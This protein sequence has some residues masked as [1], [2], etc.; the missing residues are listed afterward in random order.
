MAVPADD[1]A[2]IPRTAAF[3]S[4]LG[5]LRDGYTFGSRRFQR[6]GRDVFATRIMLKPVICMRGPEAARIFYDGDRFTRQGA[7][8]ASVRH[9]LQDD[10]SVQGLDGAAHRHRK[11]LFMAL[12]TDAAAIDRLVSLF[13]DEWRSALPRWH[14]AGQIVLADELPALLT[15][16]GAAWAGVP[17]GAD[18]RDDRAAELEAMV[19]NAGRVGPSNW[20]ARWRRRRTERWAE[21]ALARL[22]DRGAAPTSPAARLAD[23][24]DLDGR[25]LPPAIAAVE[26]INLLRPIV[27]VERY[28][29]FAALALHEH[30]PWRA[31][32]AAG[33]EA[34]LLP[35]VQEVR[36]F[37]PFFPAVAGRVRQAFDWQGTRFPVGQWVLLDIHG[38]N[39]HPAVWAAPDSFRPERFRDWDEDPYRMVPQGAG[40]A[41]ETH[42]CPGERATI[43]LVM[44][45]MRLLTRE[46]DWRLPPQD[47]SVRLNR[48]PAR[49]ASGLAMTGITGLPPV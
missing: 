38:T 13:A 15:R 31:R 32:F 43:A 48:M 20:W 37:Y 41:A 36:R 21:R 14:A 10:G 5:F 26:L 23:H 29:V 34:D 30:Q 6:L 39:H 9:L 19:A 8:P 18:Q 44:A 40:H 28:I 42:R 7:M 33:D 45:A 3:D 11:A 12:L 49:P 47:L 22:P 35:F 16:A 27:A 1:T 2:P 4:S 24:H 17:V 46:M 25:G